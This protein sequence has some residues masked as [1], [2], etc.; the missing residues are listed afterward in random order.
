VPATIAAVGT[1]PAALY[2]LD[3]AVWLP[4]TAMG[5]YWLWRGR[6]W[7]QLI[8]A[9]MLVMWVLESVTVAVDQ[10][11]GALADPTSSVVSATMTPVFLSVAA[12]TAVPTAVLL[13]RS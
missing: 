10:Y 12:L 3:L 5:A 13:R 8:A 4:L 1:R 11:F 2:V 7:G 9:S 6:R